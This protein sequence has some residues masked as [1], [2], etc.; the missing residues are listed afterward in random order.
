MLANNDDDT[1]NAMESDPW[2][3]VSSCETHI[4]PDLYYESRGMRWK[5][6]EYSIVKPFN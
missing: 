4:I 5:N 1:T 6:I 3:M 2:M